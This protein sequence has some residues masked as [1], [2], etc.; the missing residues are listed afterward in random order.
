MQKLMLN[1]AD[2]DSV[3]VPESQVD[4]ELD[5]RMR[6][7]IRQIGSEEQLEAYFHSSIRQ[8]KLEFRDMIHDQLLVQTMQSKITKDVT[9]T[10]NDVRSYF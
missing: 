9:C 1:Q 8:L 6:Y 2:I 5:R 3:T 7:Y 4:G 10:P